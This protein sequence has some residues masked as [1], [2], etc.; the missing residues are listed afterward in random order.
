MGDLWGADLLELMRGNESKLTLADYLVINFSA[1]DPLAN[2]A[3]VV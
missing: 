2:T 1:G 3:L